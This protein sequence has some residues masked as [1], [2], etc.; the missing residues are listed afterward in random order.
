MAATSNQTVPPVG[1]RNRIVIDPDIGRKGGFEQIPLVDEARDGSAGL[2]DPCRVDR[3]DRA[4]LETD[5]ACGFRERL[6][7]RARILDAIVKDF[8]VRFGAPRG[9]L[10]L[11]RRFDVGERFEVGRLHRCHVDQDAAERA[12]DGI[13]RRIDRKAERRVGHGMIEDLIPG[14]GAEVD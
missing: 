8:R 12:L 4:G 10:A 9:D 1:R 11:Q 3:L 13:A 5:G 6:A 14:H 2:V 7:G